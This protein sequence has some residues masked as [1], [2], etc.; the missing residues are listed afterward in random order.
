MRNALWSLIEELDHHTLTSRRGK[1]EIIPS[2]G[3]SS[4]PGVLGGEQD[5]LASFPA[6]KAPE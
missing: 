6:R 3:S 4:D 1:V 5:V 2:P